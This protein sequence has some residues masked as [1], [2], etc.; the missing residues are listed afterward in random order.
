MSV[1]YSGAC[2]VYM[3]NV[4]RFVATFAVLLSTGNALAEGLAISLRD[5]RMLRAAACRKLDDHFFAVAFTNGE[6]AWLPLDALA[7]DAAERYADGL[8]HKAPLTI[9]PAP[10]REWPRADWMPRQPAELVR[11]LRAPGFGEYRTD[12]PRRAATMPTAADRTPRAD[13]P[14]VGRLFYYAGER[15]LPD[16]LGAMSR[17]VPGAINRLQL[18]NFLNQPLKVALSVDGETARRIA[19]AAV[20]MA[21]PGDAPA[22]LTQWVQIVR[23]HGRDSDLHAFLAAGERFLLPADNGFLPEIDAVLYPLDGETPEALWQHHQLALLL[24]D[25]Q[26]AAQTLRRFETALA[27][28]PALQKKHGKLLAGARARLLRLTN[29]IGA[30][31]DASGQDALAGILRRTA[32]DLANDGVP[33]VERLAGRSIPDLIETLASYSSIYGEQSDHVCDLLLYLIEQRRYD[34][35]DIPIGTLLWGGIHIQSHYCRMRAIPVFALA[36]KTGVLNRGP[37]HSRQ[38]LSDQF[39]AEA[40]IYAWRMVRGRHYRERPRHVHDTIEAMLLKSIS[41]GLNAPERGKASHY[42]RLAQ[43]NYWSALLSV[44]K[45]EELRADL[46]E[47]AQTHPHLWQRWYAANELGRLNLL[48]GRY[49]EAREWFERFSH[50]DHDIPMRAR[51]LGSLH[52][53]ARHSKDQELLAEVQQRALA[54]IDQVNP[55]AY[56]HRIL[57]RAAGIQDK[58]EGQ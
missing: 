12:L 8:V 5:G 48:A 2:R 17:E 46:A 29:G 51:A 6:V 47:H 16:L 57:S 44:R 26:R 28:D 35:L 54:L 10:R 22:M 39:A 50:D 30:G 4:I 13:G 58:R 42:G 27:A 14:N 38:V 21:A 18:R 19:E 34:G 53:L 40:G 32:D 37:T 56:T 20:R 1:A 49:E 11:V 41:I 55:R 15:N 9:V 3:L 31:L 25:A 24:G 23:D 45:K 52:W 7:P 43:R 33:M 36:Q